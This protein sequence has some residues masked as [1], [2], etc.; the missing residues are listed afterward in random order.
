M[1]AVT[2]FPD[3]EL[4]R[5]RWCRWCRRPLLLVP[6]CGAGVGNGRGRQQ[7]SVPWPEIPPSCP[8]VETQ[9]QLCMPANNPQGAS[10]ESSTWSLGGTLTA[11]PVLPIPPLPPRSRIIHP[12]PQQTPPNLRVSLRECPRPRLRVADGGWRVPR[13]W[14]RQEGGGQPAPPSICTPLSRD[15]AGF[16]VRSKAACLFWEGDSDSSIVLLRSWGYK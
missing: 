1:T 4:S 16:P 13:Q 15:P 9:I 6:S 12:P 10:R 8:D 2:S 11:R 14:P 3:T 5:C 7:S